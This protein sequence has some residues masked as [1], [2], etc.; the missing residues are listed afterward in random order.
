MVLGLTY[1]VVIPTIQPE[2]GGADAHLSYLLWK[3]DA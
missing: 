1:I 2:A 3:K